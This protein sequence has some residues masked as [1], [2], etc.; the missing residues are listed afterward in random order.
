VMQEALAAGTR[1]TPTEEATAPGLGSSSTQAEH[2]VGLAPGSRAEDK[3]QRGHRH[4]PRARRLLRRAALGNHRNGANGPARPRQRRLKGV[5]RAKG[6]GFILSPKES[7]P[8]REKVSGTFS[9][10]K[11]KSFA[12]SGRR[13]KKSWN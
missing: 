7:E 10:R 2:Q 5:R 9:D 8:G 6:K 13:R 12:A 4:G 11:Q 1:R 3:A